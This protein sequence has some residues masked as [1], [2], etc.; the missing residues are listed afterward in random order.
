MERNSSS[1]YQGH[2]QI[3]HF[4]INKEAS[5]CSK[6]DLEWTPLSIT[7]QNGYRIKLFNISMKNMRT[8]KQKMFENKNMKYEKKNIEAPNIRTQTPLHIACLNG[9]LQVVNYHIEKL[10][11]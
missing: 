9:H 7:C 1:C 10:F 2:F 6:N 3:V 4:L 5:I 11:Q 8:L